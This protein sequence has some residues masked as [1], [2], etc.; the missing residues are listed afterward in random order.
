MAEKSG[1]LNSHK[2]GLSLGTLFA[3]MHAAW[4]LM[5][6]VGSSNVQIFVNWIYALHMIAIPIAVQPFNLISA[7]E[8]VI[9]TFIG[10]YVLG[11]MFA[12]IWNY[13]SK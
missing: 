8:L 11:W 5:I 2:V 6:A 3:T 10:G 4:A 7:I 9:A 1:M 13:F 12:S